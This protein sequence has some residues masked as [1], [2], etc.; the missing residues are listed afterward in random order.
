[1]GKRARR[2]LEAVWS[3]KDEEQTSI[4]PQTSEDLRS[5]GMTA[6]KDYVN[7]AKAYTSIIENL[8]N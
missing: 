2:N 3:H 5:K 6:V 4:E 8:R 7:D 1:M